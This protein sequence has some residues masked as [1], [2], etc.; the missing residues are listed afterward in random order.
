MLFHVSVMVGTPP[1]A[2]EKQQNLPFEKSAMGVV[3]ISPNSKKNTRMRA[4]S[5]F[6]PDLLQVFEM[7]TTRKHVI[8]AQLGVWAP[9]LLPTS[10]LGCLPALPTAA[11]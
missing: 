3:T 6:D 5:G 2:W 1:Q 10:P 7:V 9:S 8:A 11:G 4:I